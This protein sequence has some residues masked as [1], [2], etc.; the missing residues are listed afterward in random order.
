MRKG[1]RKPFD[2]VLGSEMVKGCSGG[3]VGLNAAGITADSERGKV[4]A[5]RF[6]SLLLESLAT[7]FPDRVDQTP[8]WKRNLPVKYPVRRRA[9]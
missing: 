6:T 1:Q 2:G 4:E 3:E 9:F 8:L 7:R 5:V